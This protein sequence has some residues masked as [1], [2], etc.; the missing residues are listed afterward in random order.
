MATFT[1]TSDADTIGIGG[2]DEIGGCPA[3]VVQGF[4]PPPSRRDE[5][6]TPGGHI[7]RHEA[8]SVFTL[9]DWKATSLWDPSFPTPEHYWAGTEPDE[10]TISAIDDD[11]IAFK[12]WLLARLA[13]EAG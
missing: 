8:G 11:V 3:R 1:P 10:L 4:G 6:K 5:H 12:E 13:G 2:L 7:F 9:S